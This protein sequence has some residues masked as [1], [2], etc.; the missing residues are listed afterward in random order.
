M[1][2]AGGPVAEMNRAAGGS[3]ALEKRVKR[4]EVRKRSSSLQM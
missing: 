2:A 1:A 4:S 3:E